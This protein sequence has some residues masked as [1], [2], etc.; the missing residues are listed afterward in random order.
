MWRPHVGNELWKLDAAGRAVL[1]KDLA[2]GRRDSNPSR[3]TAMNGT[4]FFTA[5]TGPFGRELW[6]SDG[7][8]AGTVVVFSPVQ[9][10]PQLT[11]LEFGEMVALGNTLFFAHSGDQTS[12]ELW[13][14]D[15]TPAGTVQVK[16]IRPGLEGAKVSQLVVHGAALFF[17][18]D[19]GVHGKELWRTHG[20]E[21][22]TVMV[23]DL[24]PG[25][26][27][28]SGA[29]PESRVDPPLVS[30]GNAVFLLTAGEPQSSTFELWRS[31]GTA[32]GTRVLKTFPLDSPYSYLGDHE[33]VSFGGEV[34]FG[35][36]E[37]PWL[38][39]ALWKSNGTEEG[40]VQ[41]RAFDDDMY[42]IWQA[43]MAVFF[44]VGTELWKSDGTPAGTVPLLDH[45]AG[46]F[47]LARWAGDTLFYTR[48]NFPG[49]DSLWKSDGT[50]AGTAKVRDFEKVETLEGL[51]DA[52][53]L[54][55]FTSYVES[56]GTAVVDFEQWRSDGTPGGTFRVE[57]ATPAP[58]GSDIVEPTPVGGL[59][60]FTDVAETLHQEL[61]RT[62]G[63]E[64]GTVRLRRFEADEFGMDV[65]ELT[66]VG[67]TLFFRAGDVT[68][69][70]ELWRTD[71]TEAGTVVVRDLWPGRGDSNPAWL[72]VLGGQL[73]FS[74]STESGGN[75]LWRS[76]GTAA[77]TVQVRDLRPGPAS[78]S[79][80]GLRVVG[81]TL[82]FAANDG[83]HGAELWRGDG[84]PDGMVMVKDIV[85]GSE[86]CRPRIFAPSSTGTFFF[87][88]AS[89]ELWKTD[90]TEAGTVRLKSFPRDISAL[91][92]VEGTLYFTGVDDAHGQELW[93]S[94]GTE[95]GTV[96]V[97]DV[98]PGPG[99]S[100]P[101]G[102]VPVGDRLVFMAYEPEHGLEPWVTDG[103]AEG[104]HL[105]RD[106]MP[107]PGSS[108]PYTTQW[109]MSLPDQV[110][111]VASDGV[112]GRELWVT[113]GTTAGT[114]L[115]EDLLP[116]P[117]SSDPW[118]LRR[119]GDRLF[120]TFADTE[121]GHEPH[122]LA[123]PASRDTTVPTLTCPANVTR[124]ATEAGGTRVEYPAASANDVEGPPT[125][126]YSAPSGD[127]FPV[128]TT[129]VTVTATDA[130]GNRSQC[131]FQVDVSFT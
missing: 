99:A 75:E 45:G 56:P 21:G 122:L 130:A 97:K 47:R 100:S 109:L 60:F 88:C 17:L 129:T 73:Y 40:T 84:T 112:H 107:G 103:T 66:A 46:G 33:L 91:R 48:T 126:A 69:G 118:S 7:T 26:A 30:A 27:G 50:P 28:L 79:P 117:G 29:Q 36:K 71:G 59:T 67:G 127:V 3:F 4:L 108:T 65:Q 74:A 111:F 89:R 86:G 1:I 49:P 94:D 78:A 35:A 8:A 15:G 102:V 23:G 55:F 128:G 80:S 90:G 11:A 96:M 44:V 58:R 114:T 38:R 92:A 14:S 13:K 85:P 63:T 62:D 61:W 95:A 53:D 5:S 82:F 105:L 104:T 124:E 119:L 18:A 83:V 106:V 51:V 121:H 43:D 9:R 93:R 70:N 77:G 52:G 2:P 110:L 22:S 87:T 25:P 76:D 68:S 39:R 123:L 19:D 37:Q 10:P 72:T 115:F 113:D 16:D 64:A 34:F 41:V 32:A 98:H 6:K 101:L 31:D 57:A 20:S 120:L 131:T 42:V 24:R 54:L 116:G 125:L 81:D 12:M